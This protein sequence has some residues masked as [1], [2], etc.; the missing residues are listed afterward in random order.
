MND[1]DYY[2]NTLDITYI[3]NYSGNILKEYKLLK[4]QRKN[5]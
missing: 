2:F 5:T 4:N 1:V 3:I